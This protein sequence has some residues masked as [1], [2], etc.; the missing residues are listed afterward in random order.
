VLCP[1]RGGGAAA[2]LHRPGAGGSHRQHH[3]FDAAVR[4]AP[5]PPLLLLAAR[6]KARTTFTRSQ[7]AQ[8]EDSFRRQK[9]LAA[10][11]RSAVAARLNI[12][13][14]QVKMW[15]QNRR[16]KWRYDPRPRPGEM[17]EWRD[18]SVCLSH[19]AAA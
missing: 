1:V 11:E 4:A 6:K 14:A 19:G 16:T 10:A 15:F 18:P 9:Y 3:E 2:G 5:A 12:T 8:L 13:D 17:L 7:L